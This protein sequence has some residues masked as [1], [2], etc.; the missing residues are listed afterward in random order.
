[1]SWVKK[2]LVNKP[3][4]I[5]ARSLSLLLGLIFLLYLLAVRFS[6]ISVTPPPSENNEAALS[7]ASGALSLAL[8]P[9][10]KEGR[11]NFTWG[12]KIYARAR[13]QEVSPGRHVVSF[14]W[15]NPRGRLEEVYKKPFSS[16][17]GRYNCWSWLELK[18]ADWFP[19]SLGSFG[20][21][22]FRGRWRVRVDLD[23]KLLVE[24]EFIVE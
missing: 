14:R 7:P 1:M 19:I 5:I 23:E 6:W 15:I 24:S 17:R 12:E 22:K 4:R 13:L 18:G 11:R 9:R 16:R 21:A 20:P 3:G 2:L 10:G 8:S